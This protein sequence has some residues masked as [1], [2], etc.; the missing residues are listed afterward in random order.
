MRRLR[1]LGQ[2]TGDMEPLLQE[3]V[4]GHEMQVGEI[5][6]LVHGYLQVHCPGA[7]EEYEDGTGSPVL[8][9]G[10]KEGLKP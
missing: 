9:Y 10:P 7:F 8:Y 5:L 4:Y 1:P 6:A 3:M 2:I